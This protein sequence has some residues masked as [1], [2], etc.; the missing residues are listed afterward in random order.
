MKFSALIKP[1]LQEIRKKARKYRNKICVKCD[2]ATLRRM[3]W[4]FFCLAYVMLN[5][6]VRSRCEMSGLV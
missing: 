2:N 6:N 5:K 3:D 4:Q 1:N